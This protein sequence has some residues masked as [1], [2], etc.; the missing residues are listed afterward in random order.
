MPSTIGYTRSHD[1]QR[2]AASANASVPRHSGQRRIGKSSRSGDSLR[3]R[4]QVPASHD[5]RGS[6]PRGQLPMSPAGSRAGSSTS[7]RARADD[8]VRDALLRARERAGRAADRDEA[9]LQLPARDR[10]QQRGEVIRARRV[11]DKDERGVRRRRARGMERVARGR[12]HRELVGREAEGPEVGRERRAIG[13]VVA[14]AEDRR[15]RRAAQ[16]RLD[17]HSHSQRCGM[18]AMPISRPAPAMTRNVSPFSR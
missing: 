10:R 12:A 17:R 8:L 18:R 5:G 16:E 1:V 13:R 15:R 7:A 11:L 9:P 3:R 2:N 14:R 4:A 6:R